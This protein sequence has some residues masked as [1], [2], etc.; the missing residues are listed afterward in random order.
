MSF[1]WSAGD[2]AAAIGLIL[3]I[4]QALGDADG[5]TSDYREAVAFLVNLKRTLEPLKTFSALGAFPA[6]GDEIKQYVDRIKKPIEECLEV[7]KAFE[8]GLGVH[9]KMGRHINVGAKLLWR[10]K[11]SKK[12][13]KL[14][15]IIEGHILG[16]ESLLNRLT[17]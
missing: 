17:L 5:A 8:P 13:A 14:R 1:G 3:K 12:V 2:I 16:L 15:T 4:V 9:S 7:A 11:A 10:F 6:Y